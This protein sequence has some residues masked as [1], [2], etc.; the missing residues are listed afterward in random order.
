MI[1]E[2]FALHKTKLKNLNIPNKKLII[3]F[4]GT[5]G[6]GKTYLAKKIERKYNGIRISTDEIRKII[7]KL[8]NK[9][10]KLLNE[11]YKEKVLHNYLY[12]LIE[13]CPFKNKLIILDKSIDRDYKKLFSLAKKRKYRVFII[14]IKSPKK[15]IE[16]RLVKH[17][18]KLDDNYLKNISRWI[19]E[20]K[21]F[22]EVV[23]PDL[24]IENKINK[25]LNTSKIYKEIDKIIS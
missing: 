6:S 21:N 25:K 3:C 2:I 7:K 5:P 20:F 19:K 10:K 15:D 16:K 22:W 4:S 18:G 23:K 24:V 17:R 11:S 14:R 1:K 8:R 9:N 12:Y 13:K